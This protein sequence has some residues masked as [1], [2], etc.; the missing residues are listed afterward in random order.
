[1][2]IDKLAIDTAAERVLRTRAYLPNSFD[3]RHRAK[4]MLSEMF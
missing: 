4:M 2:P 3:D 1:M